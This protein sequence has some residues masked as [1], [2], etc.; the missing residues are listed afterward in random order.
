[1]HSALKSLHQA[2]SE[3]HCMRS[4]WVSSGQPQRIPALYIPPEVWISIYEDVC[5]TMSAG[6]CPCYIIDLEVAKV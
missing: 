4:S 6:D 3:R 5:K 1:M 2:L